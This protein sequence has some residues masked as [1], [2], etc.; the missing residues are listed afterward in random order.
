LPAPK[1]GGSISCPLFLVFATGREQTECRCP[2]GICCSPAQKLV[3]LNTIIESGCRHFAKQRQCRG[4]LPALCEAKTVP[5]LVAG[6]LRSKD[7]VE[8]GC[9]HFAKQRQCRGWL[10]ALCEADTSDLVEIL[11]IDTLRK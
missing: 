11:Y 8:A 2:V 10:P 3:S 6:T 4:W 9:R 7:S 5:R 1:T